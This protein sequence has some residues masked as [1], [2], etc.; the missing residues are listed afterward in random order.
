M[1]TR[2]NGSSSHRSEEDFR[3]TQS[4][5][6]DNVALRLIGVKPWAEFVADLQAGVGIL[7]GTDSSAMRGIVKG[8]SLHDELQL[9]ASAGLTPLQE[10]QTATVNPARFLGRL[11]ELGTIEPGKLA[12]IVV[13]DANSLNDIGNVVKIHAVIAQ[14]WIS[15][16]VIALVRGITSSA[17]QSQTAYR[18]R[19]RPGIACRRVHR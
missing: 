11:D 1:R 2:S 18:P 10:L 9:M 8:S 19:R 17:G 16:S 13:P 5:Y 14:G 3:P 15:L 4:R 7:A 12:D 6:E